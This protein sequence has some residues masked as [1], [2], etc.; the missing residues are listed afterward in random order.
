MDRLFPEGALVF[1][2][3]AGTGNMVQVLLEHGAGTVIAVEPGYHARHELAARFRGD[4]RV[5]VVPQ[6][7]GEQVGRGRLAVRH[8]VCSASTLVPDV[9]WSTDTQFGGMRPHGFEDVPMTT[10]DTLVGQFG[11][12]AFANMTVVRYEW[13]ALL[14]LTVRLPYLAFAVT[15]VT[16]TQGW[17][18]MAVDRVAEVAPDARFNYGERDAIIGGQV[19]PLRWEQWVD[20]ATVK[21]I[22]PEI[23]EPGLWGRIHAKMTETA[24]VPDKSRQNVMGT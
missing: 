19:A 18:A 22:L 12:P 24:Q 15:H 13:Q 5:V 6:A 1:E 7:V 2:V 16:I 17:A 9:A 14:G 4:R 10:L 11:L 3:G 23:D 8:G 21:G 20:A